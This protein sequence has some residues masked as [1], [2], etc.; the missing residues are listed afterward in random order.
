MEKSDPI[1]SALGHIVLAFSWLEEITTRVI[2]R[3]LGTDE[4]VGAAVA[5]ELAFGKKV[6]LIGSLARLNSRGLTFN[7]SSDPE[8]ALSRVIAECFRAV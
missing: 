6:H 5:A 3:L 8:A 2:I 1:T 4:A 7:T